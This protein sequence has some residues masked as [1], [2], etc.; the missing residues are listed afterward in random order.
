MTDGTGST[1]D[2]GA[3]LR[4]LR[5]ALEMN[6]SA[7]C[8]LTGIGQSALANYESGF[9]RPDIDKAWLIAQKTGATLDWIYYGVR[10][11]LPLH[12]SERLPAHLAETR[13]AAR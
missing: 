3:R 5:A 12:L 8:K 9:R 13:Q 11:G 10:S 2:I 1:T 6:Q 7:F 4:A